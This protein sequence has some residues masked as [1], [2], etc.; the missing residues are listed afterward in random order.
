MAC[1]MF[2]S[3]STK[4]FRHRKPHLQIHKM[5]GQHGSPRISS[6]LTHSLF[7]FLRLLKHNT[8]SILLPRK[9]AFLIKAPT[10]PITSLPTNKTVNLKMLAR[11]SRSRQST[12]NSSRLSEEQID[13]LILKLQA[14]L[15]EARVGHKVL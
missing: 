4:P 8:W 6:C 9:L 5:V 3:P 14:V 10:T 2:S 15:P 1:V 12:S 11:R 13:D 7:P